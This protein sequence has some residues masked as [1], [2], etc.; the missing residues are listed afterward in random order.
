MTAAWMR[1]FVTPLLLFVGLVS[2]LPARIPIAQIKG[3]DEVFPGES[4]KYS[5]LIGA[6]YSSNHFIENLY[7]YGVPSEPLV[8][9]VRTLF[10]EVPGGEVTTTHIANNPASHLSPS[11]IARIIL[12]LESTEM[13]DFETDLAAIEELS[14]EMV[15][16]IV[17]DAD[18]LSSTR[19]GRETIVE[20]EREF[21][22]F[23]ARYERNSVRL[24]EAKSFDKKEIVPIRRKIK[25]LKKSM[26]K[27]SDSDSRQRIHDEIESFEGELSILVEQHREMSQNLLSASD[28]R[29]AKRRLG[30]KKN[31][32]DTSS[33]KYQIQMQ[34]LVSVLIHCFRLYDRSREGS[35]QM[36]QDSTKKTL[37]AYMWEKY[38]HKRYLERYFRELSRAGMIPSQRVQEE[39]L[40]V[41]LE[42]AYSEG[43][44]REIV[45]GYQSAV[46]KGRWYSE[47]FA[48]VVATVI[49]KPNPGTQTPTIPFSFVKWVKYSLF[50]DC[51]ENSLM[52]FFNHLIYN[53]EQ[54][55]FDVGV[56]ERLRADYYPRLNQKLI[57][58]YRRVRDPKEA[59]S[60]QTAT[61]WIRVVSDLNQGIEDR[62]KSQKI[63]YRHGHTH[64]ASPYTNFIR[65]VN[66][67]LG[68]DD[69][70]TDRMP[71]IMDR[72]EQ[73]TG[74]QTAYHPQKM[75]VTGFG[76]V[77][78]SFNQEVLVIKAHRPVHFSFEK[79]FVD[80]GEGKWTK[81]FGQTQRQF[82]RRSIKKLGKKRSAWKNQRYED[83]STLFIPEFVREKR[84]SL[85][86]NLNQNDGQFSLFVD[87]SMV[88]SRG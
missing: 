4:K 40:K 55:I 6:I 70:A 1:C 58:F 72:V 23:M 81:I 76:E 37:L 75:G 54:N 59:F 21:S 77:S 83:L 61:M 49:E 66:R 86:K 51:V 5:P 53:A 29:E 16:V 87:Y 80:A 12:L 22:E 35:V 11:S 27:A 36:P 28:L 50:P 19:V 69:I 39:P 34:K 20:A 30:Y 17:E 43:D 52:N 63:H 88:D 65:V 31:A 85:P 79:R 44:Y 68:Y 60:T 3:L 9:L 57:D 25:K 67:L 48:D 38:D 82:Q 64:V 56:L 71:E 33:Q 7:K 78:F 2:E 18:Y 84:G 74:V 8:E 73:V 47:H 15:K 32:N 42:Q 14:N 41:M 45:Q 26:K 62:D 10:N 24:Q 13:S 46:L